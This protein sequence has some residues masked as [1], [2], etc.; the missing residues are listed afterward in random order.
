[1]PPIQREYILIRP[2]LLFHMTAIRTPI[3]IKFAISIHI[4]F[5][6]G[7]IRSVA[8][9]YVYGRWFASC[10]R[11]SWRLTYLPSAAELCSCSGPLEY[12]TK[13]HV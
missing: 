13:N 6:R 7:A 3:H 5:S 9:S 2:I 12:P 8:S 1:M 10:A 11:C 4:V